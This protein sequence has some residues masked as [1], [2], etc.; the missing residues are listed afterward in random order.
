MYETIQ[1]IINKNQEEGMHF[2]SRDTM[3]FFK[4]KIYPVVYSGRFFITSEKAPNR[5]RMYT[6]READTKGNISSHHFYEFNTHKSAQKYIKEE[7]L[8]K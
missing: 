4:S 7:L 5:K 2:F 8:E 3:N 1:D 6:V